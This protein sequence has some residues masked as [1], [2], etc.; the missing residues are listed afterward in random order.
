VKTACTLIVFVRFMMP[1]DIVW[2]VYVTMHVVLNV[3]L[4]I[5]QS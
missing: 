1:I 5:M 3:A 4:D 2:S